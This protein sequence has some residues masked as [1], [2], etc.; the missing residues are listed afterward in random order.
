M[1][2]SQGLVLLETSWKGA[3]IFQKTNKFL[4]YAVWYVLI[5]ILIQ[6]RIEI[7]CLFHLY[8]TLCPDMW[9]GLTFET[10]IT[11]QHIKM[12]SKRDQSSCNPCGNISDLI[13][14]NVGSGF[15][16]RHIFHQTGAGNT[17]IPLG[18]HALQVMFWFRSDFNV[19][20]VVKT[21]S[22]PC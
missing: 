1:S 11:V 3:D 13:W 5:F 10:E 17:N 8:S 14:D 20:T 18:L 15:T 19:F 22:L 12:R 7:V 6:C 2:L 9:T 21:D 16:H 4:I